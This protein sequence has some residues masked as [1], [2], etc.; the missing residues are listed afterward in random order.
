MVSEMLEMPERGSVW[1]RCLAPRSSIWSQVCERVR[2]ALWVF[3]LSDLPLSF[4][5]QHGVLI[6]MLLAAECQGMAVYVQ[7]AKIQIK[8]E[9]PHVRIWQA[10]HEVP[11]SFWVGV[12]PNGKKYPCTALGKSGSNLKG[13]V[14]G[15]KKIQL[16]ISLNP[17]SICFWHHE[18]MC[19]GVG[20]QFHGQTLWNSLVCMSPVWCEGLQVSIYISTHTKSCWNGVPNALA[21]GIGA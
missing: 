20:F 12:H 4:K 9:Q 14:S 7:G 15:C 13:L 1:C 6:L 21:T 2:L 3:R 18:E 8:T 17:Q 11:V 16:P 10:C 19:V 5:V